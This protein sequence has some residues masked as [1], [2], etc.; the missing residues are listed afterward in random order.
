MQ[1]HVEGEVAADGLPEEVE[2]KDDGR[3]QVRLEE[4]LWVGRGIGVGLHELIS[5]AH[6]LGSRPW[7]KLT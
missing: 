7:K 4:D 5:N 1:R 3:R 6:E 2:E